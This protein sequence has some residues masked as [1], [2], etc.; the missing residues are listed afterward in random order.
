MKQAVDVSK[1]SPFQ[2]SIGKGHLE[3]RSPD[4][5]RSSISQNEIIRKPAMWIKELHLTQEDRDMVLN[6]DCIN[7]RIIDAA[8]GLV[9]KHVGSYYAQT[10]LPAKPPH[11]FKSAQHDSMQVVYA[12]HH[13]EEARCA[14]G[15]IYVVNSLGA[16]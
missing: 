11:G 12:N 4:N 14:E 9:A 2:T 1:H 5:T 7:D 13:W 6:G 15:K 16:T 10:R 8:N 3:S